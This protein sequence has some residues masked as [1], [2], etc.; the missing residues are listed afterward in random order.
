MP[1]ESCHRFRNEWVVRDNFHAERA[2]PSGDFLADSSQPAEAERLASQFRAGQLLLVPDAALHRGVGGW[3]RP[4]QRQH[5]RERV[6]SDADAVAARRIHDQNP[7]RAGRGEIDVVDS[8]TGAGNY[9]KFGS[10]GEQPLV[11]L[12]RAA[13]DKRVGLNEIG[14]QRVRRT[15]GARVDGPTRHR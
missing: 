9:P 13:N 15:S 6:L 12:G 5:E 1:S 2:C 10:G 7:P 14:G 4:R 3:H 8:G 11:N